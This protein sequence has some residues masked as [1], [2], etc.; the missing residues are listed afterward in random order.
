MIAWSSAVVGRALRTAMFVIAAVT[1]AATIVHVHD[2]VV[3]AVVVIAVTATSAGAEAV[4][5]LTV[6][7]STVCPL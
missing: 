2:I 6:K 7:A 3:V 1:S 4:V 5:N